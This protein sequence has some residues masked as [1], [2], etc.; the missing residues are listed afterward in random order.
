M[1]GGA[2]LSVWPP[3]RSSALLHVSAAAE[4]RPGAALIVDSYFHLYRRPSAVAP[5]SW[6][7]RARR[8]AFLGVLDAPPASDSRAMH[9]APPLPVCV[10]LEGGF[11]RHP[12]A[13]ASSSFRKYASGQRVVETGGDNFA[14]ALEVTVGA[15]AGAGAGAAAGAAP[16]A[17]QSDPSAV[18]VRSLL[19]HRI[20]AAD[21]DLRG[22]DFFGGT[23]AQAHCRFTPAGRERFCARRR[24]YAREFEPDPPCEPFVD[25]GPP[26][27]L[28]ADA[29]KGWPYCNAPTSPVAIV[30]YECGIVESFGAHDA[31][32]VSAPARHSSTH[33]T[34]G[35]CDLIPHLTRCPPA[36]AF[37][38]VRR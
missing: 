22:L 3:R 14:A 11:L 4:G 38:H 23:E 36:L 30:S 28:A 13:R 1:E 5:P 8:S 6:S 2:T 17:T 15:G 20:A 21:R 18:G 24:D 19:W 16:A 12:L 35:A 26:H 25:P 34:R 32:A 37:A 9:A 31:V 29:P 27:P 10:P 7:A 33:A